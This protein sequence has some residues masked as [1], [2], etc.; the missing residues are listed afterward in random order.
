MATYK[1]TLWEQ[2]YVGY[3]YWVEADSPEAARTA[4]NNGEWTDCELTE[5][6]NTGIV[7]EEHVYIEKEL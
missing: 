6:D 5:I 2:C 4:V 1:V 3:N 7:D